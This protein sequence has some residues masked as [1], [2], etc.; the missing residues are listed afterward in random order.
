MIFSFSRSHDRRGQSLWRPWTSFPKPTTR[1]LP[2]A[3][4]IFL[5]LLLL[6]TVHHHPCPAFC[7]QRS[8]SRKMTPTSQLKYYLLWTLRATSRQSAVQFPDA[9]AATAAVVPRIPLFSLPAALPF[10]LALL[11]GVA[12]AVEIASAVAEPRIPKN[13]LL[14][15]HLFR[16]AR[17]RQRPCKCLR[18][19]LRLLLEF[20]HV[21]RPF[22]LSPL[23]HQYRVQIL[24]FL[25]HTGRLLL[26][27]HLL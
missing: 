6:I 1:A 21:L 2:P 20:H 11:R 18:Y 15:L 5:P 23:L 24:R 27:W 14:L 8:D 13:P 17:R 9:A 7:P 25:A 26:R 16:W 10:P 22:S 12:T 19:R 4:L 3:P